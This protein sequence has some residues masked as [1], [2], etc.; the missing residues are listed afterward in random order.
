MKKREALQ[1][2]MISVAVRLRIS[3][4]NRLLTVFS[5]DTIKIFHTL[6]RIVIVKI[7]GILKVKELDLL[8]NNVHEYTSRHIKRIDRR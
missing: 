7:S 8:I 5:M 6:G 1:R 4:E 2:A 3:H